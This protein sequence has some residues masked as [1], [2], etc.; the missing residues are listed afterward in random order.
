MVAALL[1]TAYLG[2]RLAGRL[3][4]AFWLAADCCWLLAGCC[5]LLAVDRNLAVRVSL[6]LEHAKVALETIQGTTDDDE[7]D[8]EEV[9]PPTKMWIGVDLVGTS[10]ARD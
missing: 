9:E 5:L 8:A 6:T 10:L 1:L 2:W 7:A 4:A 3:A